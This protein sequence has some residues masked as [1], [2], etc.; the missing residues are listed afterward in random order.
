MKSIRDQQKTLEPLKSVHSAKATGTMSETEDLFDRVVV[1]IGE[2]LEIETDRLQ[3]T[4]SLREALPNCDSLQLFELFLYI[5]DCFNVDLDED[6]IDRV[7]TIGD[8]VDYL[9]TQL[10]GDSESASN[11]NA[12]PSAK[13]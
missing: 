3:R 6:V 8:L 13:S 2:Y 1:Y 4:S 11:S 10:P 7:Q 5:E 9:Q 12:E